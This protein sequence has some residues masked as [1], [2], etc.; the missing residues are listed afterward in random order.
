MLNGVLLNVAGS[1]T[2]NLGS[3]LMKKGV[4]PEDRESLN[5]RPCR[6]MWYFGVLLFLLGNICNFAS[7]SMANLS[8]LSSIGSIQFVTNVI[9]SRLILGEPATK[10]TLTGTFIIV[11]GDII[12][13]F[14]SPKQSDR[15]DAVQLKDRYMDTTYLSYV[16][17]LM[18]CTAIAQHVYWMQQRAGDG[19]GAIAAISFVVVSALFGTQS[20]LQGKCLSTLLSEMPN[21]RD[22]ELITDNSAFCVAVFVLWFVSTWWW[23]QR[24]TMALRRFPAFIIP[25]LQVFWIVFSILNGIFY[26]KESA[27][28]SF[29][30]RLGFIFGMVVVVFGVAVLASNASSWRLRL[31]QRFEG[32]IWNADVP[33]QGSS[34]D[35]AARVPSSP[36]LSSFGGRSIALPN[37]VRQSFY[38]LLGPGVLNPGFVLAA[39]ISVRCQSRG[40]DANG[41]PT[42][43][44]YSLSLQP[45]EPP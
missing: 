3:I 2:I 13:A 30:D 44:D 19:G 7:L 24:M 40:P 41:A 16:G 12:V 42:S 23:I 39:D 29:N 4:L 10:T 21:T 6:G 22:R 26:F 36:G 31:F 5:G 32:A 18:A 20:N 28:M 37:N 45:A 11:V 14:A 35:D 33:E 8:L 25:M 9:F 15:F 17:L 27:Y 43:P 1:T 38:S 34:A